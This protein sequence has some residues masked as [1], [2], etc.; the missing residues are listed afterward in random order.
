MILERKKKCKLQCIKYFNKFQNGGHINFSILYIWVNINFINS[1]FYLLNV[2]KSFIVN[3]MTL[4]F[5]KLKLKNNRTMAENWWY[6]F[7]P[8]FISSTNQWLT[9]TMKITNTTITRLFYNRHFIYKFI[10]YKKFDKRSL[11]NPHDYWVY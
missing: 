9:I 5:L 1:A 7:L 4:Y 10:Y 2:F 3:K 6:H 8:G 11:T